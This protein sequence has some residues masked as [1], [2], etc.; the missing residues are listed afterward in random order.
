MQLN[1]NEYENTQ[2]IAPNCQPKWSK[3]VGY[4][5]DYSKVGKGTKYFLVQINSE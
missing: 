5:V 4:V 3:Y 1:T 2:I